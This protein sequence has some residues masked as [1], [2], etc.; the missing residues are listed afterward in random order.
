MLSADR[1]GSGTFKQGQRRC[2]YIPVL[3]CFV[4]SVYHW[5]V[6][7]RLRLTCIRQSQMLTNRFGLNNR[8]VMDSMNMQNG[9]LI[10]V[11]ALKRY[12]TTIYELNMKFVLLLDTIQVQSVPE[13]ADF[14][15]LLVIYV[16]HSL[17]LVADNI[18]QLDVLILCL[19]S[20][21]HGI[22]RHLWGRFLSVFN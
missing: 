3:S 10:T 9:T 6:Q 22:L 15:S 1:R 5:F 11:W 7:F 17:A 16:M 2:F 20:P 13:F 8:I 18:P 21:C 14:L 19:H 4:Q 12:D